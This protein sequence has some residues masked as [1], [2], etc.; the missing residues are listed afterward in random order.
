MHVEIW[1]DFVCPFCYIGKRKFELAL[2]NFELKDDL[3]ITYR[4]FQLN[5][6]HEKN[7]SHDINQLIADK[8][9][10]T[11]EQAKTNND[12]IVK[13]AADVGL[14]FRFDIMKPANTSA[15]HQI[16]HYAQSVN[17]DQALVHRYFKAYFEEGADISNVDTLL[18]LAAEIGL[19]TQEIKQH[20]Q[21]ETYL[22]QVLEDQKSAKKHGINGVPYFIFNDKITVSGAQS[23]EH[24]TN[25]LRQAGL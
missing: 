8:Y 9:G 15:M 16:A 6:S 13:A 12:R 17:K 19:S 5:M 4:S 25:A 21:S 23:V 24:F 1:Y 18:D 20:L 14:D 10:M 2:A 7:K 3:K 22:P 11:Y